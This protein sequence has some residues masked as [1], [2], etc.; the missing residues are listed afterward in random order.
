MRLM[1][2][3]RSALVAFR[4]I[5]IAAALWLVVHRSPWPSGPLVPNNKVFL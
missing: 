1:E 4:S 2:R 5:G 3:R